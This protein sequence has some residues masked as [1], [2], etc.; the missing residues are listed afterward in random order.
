M[1]LLVL[2]GLLIRC[3]MGSPCS[4]E[5][6][7]TWRGSQRDGKSSETG[8]LTEW[9]A[10]GPPQLWKSAGLGNG[11]ASVSIANGQLFTMGRREGTEYLIC[12]NAETGDK[13]W[14]TAVGPGSKEN[15]PN[16]TPT[17]DENR[18][19]ALSFDGELLCAD[20]Q[21]GRELWRV[22]LPR[23]F[24]GKM[25]SMWGYSES[26]LVDGDRVICTPGGPRAIMAAL[27]KQT[28]KPVW[29]ASLPGTGSRGQ[30]GAG[31]SSIVI[32]NAGR[33]KQYVQTI[34][35][36]V[37]GVEAVTGKFLW[38][39]DRIA[40]TTANIPTPVVSGDFVLASTG[41]DDGGTALLEIKG[42]RGRISPKEVYYLPAKTL[43][44]H[45]GG[46][47]LV[48]DDV[49]MG[50]G[51]NNGF[52]T[53]FDLKSGR[54]S[55]PKQRGPGTGSA[56]VT[57]ADGHLYFRYENGTMALIEANP[58]E[59][60]LKGTFDENGMFGSGVRWAHPVIAHGKLYLRANDE[61]V[62]FD[63]RQDPASR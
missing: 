44:N 46:M 56:A 43:Q 36:G 32:S 47:I 51:H 54:T 35:R 21:S 9:P 17:I 28:G 42:T 61:L 45:H 23:D 34:G 29:T 1:R 7:P 10:Q 16:S 62:C 13:L 31:Y 40:N 14:E 19:F 5:D 8:L 48:G 12:L 20:R 24:G 50:H 55:W 37:I 4:A 41:Y 15:G 22:N 38:G 59:Y 39:Y 49:Y 60:I 6:W 52:P 57:Y 3:S 33:T 53:C 63:L 11:Y 58:R 2:F 25:M 30:D 27:N 26:V 18:V